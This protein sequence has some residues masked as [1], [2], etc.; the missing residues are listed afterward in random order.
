MAGAADQRVVLQRGGAIG[1]LVPQLGGT[2]LDAA[3]E[4]HATVVE[5]RRGVA[6]A[7]RQGQIVGGAQ[8]LAFGIEPQAAAL[9]LTRCVG[10][11]PQ[12]DASA[13]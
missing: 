9:R 2:L 10:A 6:R 11:A 13:G 12:Q 8:G 7:R 5:H 1:A 3:G 4:Q